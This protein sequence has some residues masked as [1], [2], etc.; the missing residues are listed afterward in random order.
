MFAFSCFYRRRDRVGW[1]LNVADLSNLEPT[2]SRLTDALIEAVSDIP[3]AVGGAV[4]GLLAGVVAA[5]VSVLLLGSGHASI[6]TDDYKAVVEENAKLKAEAAGIADGIAKSVDNDWLKGWAKTNAGYLFEVVDAHLKASRGAQAQSGQQPA[7]PQMANFTQKA[8]QIFAPGAPTAGAAKPEIRI[9]EFF[10]Y[11]CG[12]CK[13]V[14]PTVT[15]LL[16]ANPD[17]QV[18]FIDYPILR[19]SS[20]LAAQAGHAALKQGKYLAYH[21]ALYAAPD[22]EEATLIA[23]A[24]KT[25]LDVER[26]KG[27]LKSEE[28]VKAVNDSFNLAQGLGITGTPFFYVEGAS[29]LIPGAAPIQTIQTLVDEVRAAKKPG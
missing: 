5:P 23:L 25:G 7:G 16:A 18:T 20:R 24:G 10:D 29:R 14:H 6:T 28:T 1:R 12:Y 3:P 9:A 13:Q 2:M 17:L 27:D 8:D 4:I 22:L 19:P 21:D 26:F 11:N 15:A